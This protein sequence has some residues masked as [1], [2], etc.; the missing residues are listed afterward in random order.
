MK[1]RTTDEINRQ[2]EGLKKERTKLPHFSFFGGDNWMR[3]DAQISVL[4]G[5]GEADDFYVDESSEEYEDGDNEL[6]FDVERAEDWLNGTVDEDLF[7]AEIL[8]EQ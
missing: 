5:K 8:D 7:D 3:I 2:I 6:F 1:K 4:E